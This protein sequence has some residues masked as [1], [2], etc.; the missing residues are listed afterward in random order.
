MLPID[1]RWHWHTRKNA[2]PYADKN[3]P[4]AKF[5]KQKDRANQRGILF[6]MS[7]EEWLKIWIDSGHFHERGCAKGRY[8]MSRFGDRGPYAAWNVEIVS[9]EKNS[10]EP[11]IGRVI[12][13]EERAKI[14]A[15]LM[16]HP[17]SEKTRQAVSKAQRGKAG[18]FLGKK[19]TDETRRKMTESQLRRW[20][21]RRA[22]LVQR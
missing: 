16:G 14:S 7:F 22:D 12:S 4:R 13:A 10:R 11:H 21:T 15:G 18:E 17:V 20:A 3:S 9:H 8:V 1:V 6:E 19:H 5:S 2:M